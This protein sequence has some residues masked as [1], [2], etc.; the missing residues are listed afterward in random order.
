MQLGQLFFKRK[1]ERPDRPTPSFISLVARTSVLHLLNNNPVQRLSGIVNKMFFYI[2]NVRTPVLI[3]IIVIVGHLHNNFLN[4][5]KIMSVL[6]H[7]IITPS[8][9]K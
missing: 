6:R 7:L 8:F 2:G 9:K 5:E 4:M 3:I 1:K